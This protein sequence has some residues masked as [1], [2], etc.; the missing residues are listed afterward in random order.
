M[1]HDKKVTQYVEKNCANYLGEGKCVYGN[2]CP[3][4]YD[5]SAKC[6]YAEKAVIPGNAEIEAIYYTGKQSNKK[7]HH[8][9][10]CKL[11]YTRTGNRQQRC[12]DCAAS[13]RKRKRIIYDA[14]QRKAD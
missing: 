14:D 8:C 4:V 12:T 11:P 1:K 9:A 7:L 10:D 2:L 3:F 5:L 6:G 13:R